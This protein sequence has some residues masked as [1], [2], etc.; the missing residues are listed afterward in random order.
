MAR[1]RPDRHLRRGLFSHILPLLRL[2]HRRP[3]HAGGEPPYDAERRGNGSVLTARP[4]QRTVGD[5][6]DE[7][8]ARGSLSRGEVERYLR[9][10]ARWQKVKNI[11]VIGGTIL[12]LTILVRK[13]KLFIRLLTGKRPEP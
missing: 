3:A 9:R 6:V 1:Q 2:R 4:D 12:G 10:Y 8:V 5:V 13:R 11:S 7:Y